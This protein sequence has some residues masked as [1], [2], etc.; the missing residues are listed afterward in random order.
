MRLLVFPAPFGLSAEQ[1]LYAVH[2]ESESE[3]QCLVER[4]AL[5]RC[6]YITAV[7]RKGAHAETGTYGEVFTVTLVLRLMVIT[8]SQR[9]LV[10]IHILSTHTPVYL[11]QLFLES[12]GS[13]A[14][15]LEYT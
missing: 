6:D 5:C 15:A 12:A 4:V 9:K 2:V 3:T 7:E 10:V 13:I 8:G 11:L 1:V 14:E